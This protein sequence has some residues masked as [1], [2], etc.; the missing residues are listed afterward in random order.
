MVADLDPTTQIRGYHIIEQLYSGCRTL[1]YRA[2]R[3]SDHQPV[4]IKL[5]KREFP[6]FSDLLQFRNQYA[7][8]NNLHLSGVIQSYSLESY[9]NSYALVM[10]DFGGISVTE[11]RESQG[12]R[13]LGSQPH[14]LLTDFLAIALQLADILSGLY[15]HR[16]IHKDLKPA[17]ILINPDT[18]QVK[19]TDFSIASLL[20]KE[21]QEIQSPNVLEGT[22]AYLSP[23]QTGRMNRGIDY[24][25]DFYSLGVTFFELLSG[26][27]PFQSND[28]MEIVH[29]QIAKQPP[30][31]YHLNP[32][33]PPV[34]SAI[35]AKL[36]AKNAEDRYQS[37]LGLKYDLETCLHQW[38]ETSTIA[39]FELGTWDVSDRFVIPEK[40]YGRQA[41]VE[42]LLAAFNRVSQGSAEIILVAGFSGIGKTAVVN[43]V[44]KPIGRQ[45]GYFIK[46]KYDQFQRHIP[47]SA[48]VQAFRDLMG[49][50]LSESDAQLEQWKT[51]ILAALGENGQVMIDVIPEL[52]RI[53]GKQPTP[54]EISGSAAQNRFNLLF[55]K[56]IQVFT[57]REH[58]LVIF[59]DDLQWADSASLKLMQLLMSEADT[60]Y[61]LFLGAYRDN[62]VT[63]AHPLMLTLEEIQKSEATVHPITLAP[64]AP[65]SVNQLVADTLSCSLELALPLT[66][67]VLS[68]T[69]GNPFFT[70]QFLK[71][72]YEDGLITFNFSGGY[73]E[74]DIAR[75]RL[76]ALT[77]DVV[78]F[79]AIQLQKLPQATQEV[80][81]L[82]ACV[83]NQ[84]DLTTLAIVYENSQTETAGALWKALQDGLVIPT[85]EVYKFYHQASNK[86][87]VIGNQAEGS[88]SLITPAQLSSYRF[89]HDRVQQAAYFLIPE[90]QKPATHLKLGQLLLSKTPETE[91]EEKIFEIVNQLNIGVTLIEQQTERDELA[92]LNL[93][94]GQK[95]RLS[96]AYSAASKYANTGI[97]LLAA[98]SWQSRYHL[99]LA[100]HELAAEVAY[101]GG[102]FE[103]MEHL[104]EQVIQRAKNLLDTIKVYEVKLFS[105][106]AQIRTQEALQ[107]GLKVLKQLEIYLSEKS[108]IQDVKTN[109][110]AIKK[111]FFEEYRN[112]IILPL[113]E[114]PIHLGTV[115]LL[116]SIL[117]TAYLFD[118][119]FC[120]LIICEQIKLALEHGNTGILAYPYACFGIVLIEVEEDIE[121]AYEFGELAIATVARFNAKEVQ[122]RTLEVFNGHI[123]HWKEH[124]KVTLAPLLKG[125]QSALDV[126]DL[127]FA[128]YNALMY[129]YHSYFSSKELTSLEKEMKTYGD[130]IR[131]LKHGK[132]IYGYEIYHQTIINL[133]EPTATPWNLVGSIYDERKNL[134]IHLETGDSTAVATLLLNKTI[135]CYLFQKHAQA[136]EAVT[137]VEQYLGSIA[138]Q[139][140]VPV[141]CLYDSLVRLAAYSNATISEQN[142][143]LEKVTLNQAKMQ[144][145]AHYAPMNHLHRYHLVEAERQRI[146]GHKAE[147]IELYDRAIATAK[148]NEYFQ[149]EALANEL[150]AKFYLEW[151]RERL[152]QDYLIDAYYCYVR[153]G[154]I[155]KVCDLEQRYPQLLASVLQQERVPLT[156]DITIL[157]TGGIASTHTSSVNA[158]T[159]SGSGVSAALDLETVLKVSQT[160]SSE[161]RLENLLCVLM[162]VVLENAGA[163]KSALLLLKEGKL[164]VEAMAAV[165]QP[166]IVLQS[167]P[168]EDSQDLP[169]APINTVKRTLQTLVINATVH[170]SLMADPYI[171]RQQP[172]S[173]LC[174]PIL[175]QGKLLGILYLENN[176][177][178]GAFTSDRL[179]LLQLLITQAAIALENA[180]LYAREQ[181]R[182]QALQTSLHQLQQS[183]FRLKQLFEKSTDA[184]LLLG[185]NGFVNCN[186]AAVNLLG[187]SH[188]DQ[189]YSIHPSQISPEFQPDGQLSFDKATAMVAVAWQKGNHQFE[190]VHKRANGEEFWAEVTLTLIP[191]EDEQI[192]HSLV[193]DISESHRHASLRK[194]AEAALQE[195][196]QFL[197]SIYEGVGCLIF[198]FDVV[199][200]EDFRYTGWSLS[201]EQATG[202][203]AA[204]V[205][206]KNPE[207]TFGASEGATVHQHYRRCLQAGTSITYEESLTFH[208]QETWWLTTLNPL[209][210]HEGRIYRVVGTTINISDRKAAEVALQIS[211]KNL[212]TIFNNTSSAIFIHELDGTIRD[213]NDRML[214]MYGLE[215]EQALKLS[216]RDDYSAPDNPM[217]LVQDV[218][219]RALAGEIFPFEWKS[220]RPSDGTFFDV[221]I[222]FSKIIL[223]GQEL[224]LANVQDISDRQRSEAERKRAEACLK[225][226][227]AE[228]ELALQELQSTQTQVIQ[229]EKMSSLGQLVAGVAHEINNPVNFISGNLTHANDYIKDILGLLSL[230]QRHYPT[231]HPDIQEEAEEID[232]DFL[233]EDLPKLLSSMRLGAERIQKIVASLR[234]FSRM[235]E[236]EMKAVD[237]HNGIDSTLMILQHRLKAKADRPGIEITKNYGNLPLVEC[238]AGQLNQ[239]FMN[240]LSNAIDALEESFLTDRWSSVSNQGQMTIP[241]I[242]I[243]TQLVDSHQVKICITDNGAGMPEKV[244]QRLFNP[245]FTT[246]PVG[247]GT[248]MGL[249]ISYQIVTEKH[250][251]SLSCT[252]E[253]GQGAE[254]IIQI[255]TQQQSIN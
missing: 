14:L 53:V 94:A 27:L 226:Q 95:A 87:A 148:A 157:A 212:R 86:T 174:A 233:L 45:R 66:E 2:I 22:L 6:T 147:A 61:L 206:G 70:T 88:Q 89:L 136:L 189:L 127:E 153:W 73:W 34:L 134:P 41:E 44:H 204:D 75:V 128:A 252:S 243:C 131:Q 154:A 247:K 62:E 241:T 43:E 193:R 138:G 67:L 12:V 171:L 116:S 231:P 202:L 80:L 161:I 92:G 36:M 168:L 30:A 229:A 255:P 142:K 137:N 135:L 79:M 162:E 176:L 219:T 181:D 121:S 63:L 7:I 126:G 215:R 1:V 158:S 165:E 15:Q 192:L 191:Y 173:V 111:C 234:T 244:R 26:Q 49:Q 97:E 208:G 123:R 77:D 237:I 39:P 28:P 203:R 225:Q 179:E 59:I 33:V 175:H 103:Q 8:T 251:G 242:T 16:I 254:F 104:T 222:V 190:W 105:L 213:V 196:E 170:S 5:L 20:P 31:I 188:K 51:K 38:Q 18:K 200:N 68:K 124:I 99:T 159:S 139:A 50:L 248:G 90:H 112:L 9:R 21:T 11:W 240:V 78:E 54:P 133:I 156:P 194:Q 180:H 145:W 186:Q 182:S 178:T 185:N 35:V 107:I 201:A 207:A 10:E 217:H 109:L 220:R 184:I 223:D 32:E 56:F 155:A 198:V 197:R 13:E 83:G 114:D 96:T 169:I 82:A 24:R 149:E 117:P 144:R 236:A 108:T 146:L 235:D 143:L 84:F 160:L 55:Q 227:A 221:E 228:L 177:A 132:A 46:G 141:L 152:A 183:E 209:K 125:Y 19:L 172:K 129:C 216:I 214:E 69:K 65:M 113:M 195:Q 224:I 122:G 238:Y 64:L 232:L 210:D 4:V 187:Y 48:F 140:G 211:E 119:N 74:C 106:A 150:A 37:T 115:K 76:L 47:F 98:D 110:T 3:E 120:F 93:M 72:L 60:R 167:L 23:E 151:G 199:E 91:R 246:K 25:S 58:P 57:T 100:L 245:F 85:S 130:A 239:V 42:T 164:V 250:G 253:A 40:L 249:S 17:N 29:S 52:E 163:D 81:K 218:W 71:A 205:I 102:D 118:A 230:Y 166:P 101:L